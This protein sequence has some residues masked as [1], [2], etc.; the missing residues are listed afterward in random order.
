MLLLGDAVGILWELKFPSVTALKPGKHQLRLECFCPGCL[1]SL[2]ERLRETAL[3]CVVKN[4]GQ[5]LLEMH[6]CWLSSSV[7]L[8]RVLQW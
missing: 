8:G 4:C 1:L 3:S 7:G 2:Q 5:K 6:L